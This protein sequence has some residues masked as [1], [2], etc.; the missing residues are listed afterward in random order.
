MKPR[1]WGSREIHMEKTMKWRFTFFGPCAVIALC[2]LAP[3]IHPQGAEST[4]KSSVPPWY[5]V[6]KEVT[7]TGTVSSVMEKATP[8]MKMLGGSHVVVETSSRRVVDASLGR[9]AMR[10]EGSLSV[11]LGEHIQLTGV[12]KV[13]N[14]KEVLFTRLVRAR[15]HLYKI[16]NEHGYTLAPESNNG[17]GDSEIKAERQ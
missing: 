7:L 14:D 5:D 11:T 9:L 3:P 13:I 8:E 1:P 2:L 4:I 16:R 6:T 15:G 17:S 12:M 10:G